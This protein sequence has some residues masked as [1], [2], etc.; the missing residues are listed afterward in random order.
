MERIILKCL[1]AFYLFIFRASFSSVFP[2]YPTTT[3][4]EAAARTKTIKSVGENIFSTSLSS[5]VRSRLHTL[6]D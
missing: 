1:L 2:Q 6:L 5:F 3:T 4:T